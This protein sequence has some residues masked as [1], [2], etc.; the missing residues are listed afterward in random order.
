MTSGMTPTLACLLLLAAEV[1]APAP[2]AA[3]PPPARAVQVTVSLSASHWIGSTFGSP[4]GMTTPA[5]SVAVRPGLKWLELGLRYSLA[6]VPVTVPG[7]GLSR[8]GFISLDALLTRELRVAE[9]R[10]ALA[11]GP[12]GTV[13]HSSLGAGFG[14]SLVLAARYLIDVNERFSLGPFFAM[15]PTFYNLPGDAKLLGRTDAQGDIGVVATF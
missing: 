9:Q 7:G 3:P 1:E 11:V 8:V 2:A 5:L 13:I 6:V 15:R 12:S 10:F 14:V 4:I